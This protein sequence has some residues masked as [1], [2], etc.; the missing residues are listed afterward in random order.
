[1]IKQ[2]RRNN[3]DFK[4]LEW[5]FA[6]EIL[7]FSGGTGD[8]CGFRFLR[9]YHNGLIIV[10][11]SMC[12]F[13]IR[14]QKK[15]NS[16]LPIML[17][18]A[19]WMSINSILFN[20]APNDIDPM[21]SFAPIQK[22]YAVTMFFGISV[23]SF[24]EFREILLKALTYLSAATLIVW[25]FHTLGLW[26]ANPVTRRVLVFRHFGGRIGSIYWEPGQ[27]QII[28]MF[29]LGLF[30]DELRQIRLSNIKYYI[31]KFGIVFLAF[32]ICR[33]TT[34]Y[35]SL[36]A[37]IGASFMFNASA[38]NNKIVYVLMLLAA[39]GV[40]FLIFNSDVV[41]HKMNLHQLT[42][43]SSYSVRLLDNIA[44][45]RMSLISPL[46]GIGNRGE[47]YTRYSELFF[48]RTASNGWLTGAAVLGWPLVLLFV[49]CILKNIKR[50]K[51]GMPALFAFLPL[52]LSQSGEHQMFFP[53]MYIYAYKF[54][55]YL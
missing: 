43:Q 39:I 50:M 41:Q 49:W 9:S 47:D 33:S 6:W 42:V 7:I 32:V 55:D 35:F 10:V 54:K 34:G 19:I 51:P 30:V 1:M 21:N 28:M 27:Y 26:S 12:L 37:L 8:A 23:L 52:L 29:V 17:I 5:C 40:G 46:T 22:I 48:N 20:I 31:K 36:M 25:V 18:T 14:P 4:F 13:F 24:R 2:R 16:S 38:K 11:T 53:I 15:V 44:C 3:K 45:L